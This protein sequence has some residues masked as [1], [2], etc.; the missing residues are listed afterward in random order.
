MRVSVNY[1][2][3]LPALMA[4]LDH[5]QGP[6]LELGTGV[7]STPFLHYYC[8]LHK[9][10]LVS[11]DNSAE[12]NGWVDYYKSP[13]HEILYV[14]DWDKAQIEKPWD[15]ALV[16]HSPD[17]RRIVE[18]KRL[19]NLAKYIIIHDSNARHEKTYHYSQIYPLFTYRRT[20]N[21]DNRH[22]DILSNFV[23]LDNLWQ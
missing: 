2:T 22:T 16:D 11:Y 6:V 12:W 15:V 5:T 17:V 8:L 23:N 14:D 10:H 4:V 20:W 19:A 7:F 21:S 1:G 3:H 9:R 13:D 18:V